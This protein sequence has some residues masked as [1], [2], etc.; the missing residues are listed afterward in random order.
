MKNPNHQ[1][2][3]LWNKKSRNGVKYFSG[4]LDLGPLFPR[5]NIVVFENENKKEGHPAY[6]IILSQPQSKGKKEGDDVPF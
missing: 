2:G 4:T 1:L 6:R 3:T 5:L